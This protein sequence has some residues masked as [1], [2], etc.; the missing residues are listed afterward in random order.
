MDT[1]IAFLS[2]SHK[3]LIALL[4]SRGREA[5]GDQV[6][7]FVARMRQLHARHGINSTATEII[8]ACLDCKPN[9]TMCLHLYFGDA[10]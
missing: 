3:A 1:D 8:Q 4:H 6:V 10:L 2:S 5:N 7:A 9:M